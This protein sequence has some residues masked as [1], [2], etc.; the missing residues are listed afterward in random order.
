MFDDYNEYADPMVLSIN[1]KKYEIPPVT[2]ADGLRL[3]TLIEQNVPL[4]D[5]DFRKIL[6]GDAGVQMIADGIHAATYM[7]AL[8]TALSE[9]RGGRA[10]AEITWASGNDPK[11]V[12]VPTTP[13]D[14]ASTTPSQGS[15]SG[16]T[17]KTR[18]SR[19]RKSS[20]TGS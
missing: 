2:M 6:L 8:V 7:R 12:P 3:T 9:F 18:P 11:A 5:D 16:T 19:S 15:G 10:A 4:A 1:G 20:N 14:G 17:T 13:E